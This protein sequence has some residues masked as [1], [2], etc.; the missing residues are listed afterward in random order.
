MTEQFEQSEPDG[1]G[2]SGGDP[3]DVELGTRALQSIRDFAAGQAAE[4]EE[5]GTL[6]AQLRVAV[7]EPVV[8]IDADAVWQRVLD[9]LSTDRLADTGVGDHP[10]AEDDQLAGD[11][12]LA[13]G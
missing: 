9:R 10:L 5:F 2:R 12:Y 8:A 4:L 11:D 7:G 13:D 1:A 6:L 3:A